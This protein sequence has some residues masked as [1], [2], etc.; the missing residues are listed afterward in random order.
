MNRHS[1]D[2]ST[3]TWGPHLVLALG[4]AVLL[5]GCDWLKPPMPTEIAFRQSVI[6]YGRVAQIRNSSDKYLVVRLEVRNP[7]LGTVSRRAIDL[8]PALTVEVGWLQGCRL[9]TGD[10]LTLRHADFRSIRVTVP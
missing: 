8:P 4:L 10:R 9:A 1:E 7:T 6:H 3:Y 5:G 2:E